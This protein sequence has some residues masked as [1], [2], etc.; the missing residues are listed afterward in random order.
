MRLGN[1]QRAILTKAGRLACLRFKISEKLAGVFRKLRH[2]ARRAELSDEPR[3]VPSRA[4]RQLLALAKHD[5]GDTELRQMISNRDA[6][7]P[8]TDNQNLDAI[9]VRSHQLYPRFCPPL[10]FITYVNFSIYFFTYAH[11]WTMNFHFRGSHHLRRERTYQAYARPTAV[12]TDPANTKEA[13]ASC[14]DAL[15]R[16]DS[17]SITGNVC[18]SRVVRNNAM[19]NSFSDVMNANSPAETMPVIATG[20]MTLKKA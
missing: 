10:F 9:P 13:T 14:G 15:D 20:T 19:I 5:I 1:A 16:S 2:I 7:N 18:V 3:S 17:Q 8:T 4:A 6:G 11:T 12:K